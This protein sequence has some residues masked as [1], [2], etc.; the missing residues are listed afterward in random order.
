MSH[1][2]AEPIDLDAGQ[3]EP[4][5]SPELRRWVELAQRD[6][7][8]DHDG[9]ASKVIPFPR[10]SWSDPDFDYVSDSV[11]L[12]Q[13]RSE[14]AEVPMSV[15]AGEVI[16]GSYFPAKIEVSAKLYGSRLT[17]V[18]IT[19]KKHTGRGNWDS[20]GCSLTLEEARELALVLLAAAD[21]GVTE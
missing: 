15:V 9:D 16:G 7:D 4:P 18:G 11:R 17:G 19:A 14:P 21:L 12:T 5:Q 6:I 2:S 8:V 3:P 20:F 10:P 13:Y 1:H